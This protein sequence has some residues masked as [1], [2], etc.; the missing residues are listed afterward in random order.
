MEHVKPVEVHDPRGARFKA[1]DNVKDTNWKTVDCR[2]KC[3]SRFDDKTETCSHQNVSDF[4]AVI[5]LI[6]F[7]KFLFIDMVMVMI[8][9]PNILWH[10]GASMNYDMYDSVLMI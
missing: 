8:S 4:R 5:Q 9:S 7:T 2:L 3:L 6:Y 10:R 1:T